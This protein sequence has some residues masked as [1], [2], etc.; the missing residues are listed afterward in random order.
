MQVH[1]V[2]QELCSESS[3][4]FV[5]EEG[6]REMQ[7]PPETGSVY[8]KNIGKPG[9]QVWRVPMNFSFRLVKRLS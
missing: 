1:W 8:I 7:R 5:R 4:E 3:P 9:A 6:M 2:V